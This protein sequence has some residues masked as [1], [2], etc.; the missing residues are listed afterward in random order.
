MMIESYIALVL[1]A[2]LLLGAYVLRVDH[3]YQEA[4]R[5]QRQIERNIQRHSL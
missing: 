2:L 1:L 3:V 5:K 4:R